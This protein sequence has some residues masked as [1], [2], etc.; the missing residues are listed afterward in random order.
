MKRTLKAALLALATV[1]SS[2]A[3]DIAPSRTVTY[4]TVEGIGLKLDIFEP[5]GLKVTDQRPAIVFFFGGGWS[6]GSTRQF[7]QQ[8]EFMA[9][10]GMVAVSADYRVK[11]RNKTTPFECVQDGKSAIRWVRE[12]AAELG[13]APNRIVAAGGSA[14]G[15]VAAC[16]GII[17]DEQEMGKKLPFSSVPNAMILFNPVLDTT[18]AG[19]GA[20]EF[21]PERQTDISPCHHVRKGIVPTLILHGTADRTV[22]FENA[23]RFTRLMQEAGNSCSLIPFEGRDH[24][25]FN[26][27]FFRKANADADFD[28]TMMHS[29]EFLKAHRFL[30]YP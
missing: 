7:Y 14:G 12:H 5:A 19:Y 6:S 8:A 22:P 23:Q 20:K 10:Q 30:A 21:R 2:Q 17:P 26:G 25:F 16:T 9:A 3:A 28:R 24:G 13:V 4:K 27:S 29:I 1:W 11:A 15:H 18:K